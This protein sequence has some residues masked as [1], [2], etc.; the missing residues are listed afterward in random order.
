MGKTK[1]STPEFVQKAISVHGSKYDYSLVEYFHSQSKVKIICPVHGVF[2][3]T[4]SGHTNNKLGCLKCKTFNKLTTKDFIEKAVAVHGERYDYSLVDYTHSQAKVKIICKEHGVF[5]QNP[6]LHANN[7][8]GCPKCG[9]IKCK[10]L[11]RRSTNEFIEKAKNIHGDDYDYSLVQY[12][13]NNEKVKI[14][15][16]KHGIFEQTPF[17]HLRDCGCPTCGDIVRL[18][19]HY[20]F[21]NSL[22]THKELQTMEKQ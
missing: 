16:P 20:T 8:R 9:E 17:N 7:K 1:L 3:Q 13:N 5:E 4:P 19:Y 22:E 10:N 21:L 11:N 18:A 14:I 2:E 12:V 6:S 15:C